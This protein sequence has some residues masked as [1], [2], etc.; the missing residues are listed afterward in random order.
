MSRYAYNPARRA[1]VLSWATD[2]GD[3]AA[4]VA[5]LPAATTDGDT[6]D[7]LHEEQTTAVF[8][9]N[10]RTEPALRRAELL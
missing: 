9:E 8:L 4:T 1:L 10:V 5:T 2:A 6:L 7:D 3:V